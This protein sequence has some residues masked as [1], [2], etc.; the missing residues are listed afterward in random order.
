MV[1]KKKSA[2]SRPADMGRSNKSKPL[3]VGRWETVSQTV[4]PGRVTDKQVFIDEIGKGTYEVNRRTVSDAIVKPR[5]KRS[6][7]G[8]GAYDSLRQSEP[9]KKKPVKK[10]A[11]DF[12]SR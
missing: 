11:I 2:T 9:N 3:R 5:V 7:V 6:G 8:M 1:A 12:G 4:K 10:S